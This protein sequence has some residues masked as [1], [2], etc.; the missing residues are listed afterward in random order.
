MA[1]FARN[2]IPRLALLV[3]LGVLGPACGSGKGRGAGNSLSD[4]VLDP[5]AFSVIDA[6]YS[7][8]LDRIVLVSASPH[9]LHCFNPSTGDDRQVL[10]PRAPNCVSVSPDGLHAAV[11]FD[12]LICLIDLTT[13]SVTATYAADCDVLDVVLAANGFVY[14][15]PRRDQWENIRCLT[16]A[17]GIETKS[18]GNQIYAGTL[19][20]L[21]PGGTAIYGAQNGIGPASLEKYDI[22]PGTAAWSASTSSPTTGGNLW[23][24][25]DG[26]KI[27]T[28][29]GT[30][31]SPSLGS[32]G[33]LSGLTKVVA[34]DFAPTAGKILAVP[35]VAGAALPANQDGEIQVFDASTFSLLDRFALPRFSNGSRSSPALGR[36]VF[37]RAGEER[38][39]V[40]VQSASR[41]GTAS[42]GVVSYPLSGSGMALGVPGDLRA[43]ASI[44]T[45]RLQWDAVPAATGYAIYGATV[46][47]VTPANSLSLPGGFKNTIA[48]PPYLNSSLT[49]GTT[50]YFVVTATS[51]SAESPPS[52]EVSATPTAST[53]LPGTPLNGVLTPGDG[54][55]TLTW[56]A[57]SGATSYTVYESTTPGVT[58]MQFDQ[59]QTTAV[60]SLVWSG[61]SNNVDCYFCISASNAA[62][63]GPASIQYVGTPHGALPPISGLT[64]KVIDAEYSKSLDRIVMVGA[65]PN[66]L[67]VLDPTGGGETSVSLPGV[68]E[69]VSISPSGTLAAVGY[70]GSV[71]LV[72]LTGP[73]VSGTWAVT[74]DAGHVVLG[75]NGFIYVYGK[76]WPDGVHCLDTTTGTETISSYK[77]VY[78]GSFA[79]LQPGSTAI[80]SGSTGV[81][82]SQMQKFD[83]A[84][85]TAVHDYDTPYFGDFPMAGNLWYKEDGSR[86]ISASGTTFST[87]SVQAQDMLYRG[88]LPGISQAQSFSH[89]SA[90]RLG[91]AIP[92]TNTFISPPVLDTG[93]RFFEDQ[94]FD[95]RSQL[96]FPSF[97]VAATAYPAHGKFVFWDSTGTHCYV[98]VQAD[99]AAAL[100]LDFGVV[101]F[102]P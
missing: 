87:S 7:P 44:S 10:L 41:Q 28:Q 9:Q 71:S 94:Y 62:G 79:R 37:V 61:L 72:D 69:C 89:S 99:P 85:G 43:T 29:P 4:G 6:E 97:M 80:Y 5:L 22:S 65:A 23:V 76:T 27:L 32:L 75:S 36:W 83:T 47:G 59:L 96:V 57:T 49:A 26:Q 1:F 25:S 19:A 14:A 42:W 50:Y 100:A 91:V 30:V 11:G 86:I 77:I 101:K 17:G 73:G 16:T 64:H 33:A 13:A 98:I 67:Y 45:A 92:A 12:G 24:S 102:T 18:T 81:S 8:A 63:E 35:G 78:N 60:P 38:V 31:F 68:P 34:A 54:Q 70:N 55:M 40:V 95:Y 66:T 88:A 39:T 82:P 90:A 58:A 93:I 56:N 21:L 3:L 84:G 48:S 15:F 52:A 2:P 53:T 74:C 20:K 51:A 46:P